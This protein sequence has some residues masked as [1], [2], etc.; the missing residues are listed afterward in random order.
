LRVLGGV[1]DFEIFLARFVLVMSLSLP[2]WFGFSCHLLT[3]AVFSL[4]DDLP[5]LL[6]HFL[7]FYLCFMGFCFQTSNFVLFI[8]NGLIKG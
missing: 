6:L 3:F 5:V 7:F 8:V 4:L 1:L 2:F